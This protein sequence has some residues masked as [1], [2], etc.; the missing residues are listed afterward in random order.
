MISAME[1]EGVVEVQPEEKAHLLA[2]AAAM[3][4]KK[5]RTMRFW[6][7]RINGTITRSSWTRVQMSV[8][9]CEEDLHLLWS[10]WAKKNLVILFHY[11]AFPALAMLTGTAR[12]TCICA[13]SERTI[14]SKALRDSHFAQWVSMVSPS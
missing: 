5:D 10:F 3:P 1:Y 13:F 9:L 4:D 7:G 8:S 6:I 14:L 11:G 2:S 12:S